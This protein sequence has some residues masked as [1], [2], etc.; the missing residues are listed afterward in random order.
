MSGQ[1]IMAV[2]RA[3]APGPKGKRKTQTF[4][5][6]C[7]KPVEDKI[8]EIGSFESFLRDKIKVEGKTGEMYGGRLAMFGWPLQ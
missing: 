8:M 6:D 1:G 3:A 2:R 7:S 4:I 5:I